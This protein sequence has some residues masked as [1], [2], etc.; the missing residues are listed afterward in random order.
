[1]GVRKRV[2]GVAT[3]YDVKVSAASIGKG[4][5]K[6]DLRNPFQETEPVSRRGSKLPENEAR[7]IE[8]SCRVVFLPLCHPIMMPGYLVGVCDGASK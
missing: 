6:L 8:P 7:R 3:R 1:M 2:A 5:C 4:A